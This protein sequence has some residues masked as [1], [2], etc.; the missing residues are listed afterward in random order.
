VNLREQVIDWLAHQDAP[1]YL[2]GGGVRDLLLGRPIVDLDVVVDGDGLALARRVANYFWGAYYPLDETRSTGRAILSSQ[3]EPRLVVDVARLRG[4]D[5]AADLADRDFTINAMAANVR[6]PGDVIDR[7]NGRADLQARS[8]RPVSETSIRNDPLRALRAIRLAAQLDFRLARET[9][10]LIR[11]NGAGLSQVAG[12]RVRDELASLLAVTRAAP[13]LR[14][15]DELGLLTAVVPELEPLRGLPQSPPHHLNVLEHSLQTVDALESLLALWA[16]TSDMQAAPDSSV[17]RCLVPFEDRLRAHLDRPMGGGRGRSVI[18]KLAALLHDTGK[19]A[20]LE[21]DGEG[22]IHFIGHEM[23]GS[24]IAR[25]VLGRLRFNN[26]E[27]RLAET[28]VRYHMR[29][30]LLA[31]QRS[32]SSRAVYRLFRDS[33]DAGVEVILHALADR[34]ATCAPGIES[35]EEVRLAALAARMLADYWEHREE[36]VAPPRLIDGN[37]LLREFDL[38]A[39]PRIGELLEAVREA[40]VSGEVSTREE[41]LS[42]VREKLG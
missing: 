7:H 8:I 38:Q 6:T 10:R 41:A 42:L 18:L 39:G 11:R 14:T 29:P 40:Q 35:E 33:G 9:E 28:I 21:V 20:A 34:Q 27:V 32:V 16:G 17:A 37:D 26:V 31:K 23:G 2:V 13:H 3:D 19:P 4:P 22:Q 36:R 25:A 15:M 5:L 24:R 1:V 30:L 12:E